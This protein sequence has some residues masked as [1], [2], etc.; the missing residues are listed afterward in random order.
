MSDANLSA[1][2]GFGQR[3]LSVL[4]IPSVDRSIAIVAIV[5]FLF[6]LYERLLGGELELP[7][8]ISAISILLIVVT[9]VLRRPPV[10]VTP[11]P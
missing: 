11:N 9:M 3:L 10:R 6:R 5:P 8:L 4:L 7:R 2:P 1:E